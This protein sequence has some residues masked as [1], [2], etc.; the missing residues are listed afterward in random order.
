M[1]DIDAA[2]KKLDEIRNAGEERMDELKSQIRD[3]IK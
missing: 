1:A 3:W 2:R